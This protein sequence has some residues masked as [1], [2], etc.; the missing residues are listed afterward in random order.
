MGPTRLSNR[1]RSKFTPRLI[2]G[3]YTIIGLFWGLFSNVYLCKLGI[4]CALLDQVRLLVDWAFILV[5]AVLLYALIQGGVEALI[6]SEKALRASEEQF[7]QLAENV[8]E[9]FWMTDTKSDR[10]IYVSPVFEQ[11]WGRDCPEPNQQAGCWLD[12]VHPDERDR[13]KAAF[14]KRNEGNYNQEYR[15]LTPDGQIR[16]IRDQSFPIRNEAGEIYRICGIAHDITQRVQAQEVLERSVEER[17]KEIEQRRLVAEGLRGILAV[18]NSNQPLNI[19]LNYI[20]AQAARLLGA[21]AVSIYHL[22]DE[23]DV[24]TIQAAQGLDDDYI[25][26]VRVPVGRSITG[27]AVLKREPVSLPD[28]AHISLEDMPQDQDRQALSERLGTSYRALLAIPLGLGKDDIYGAITLYY[29][30]PRQFSAEDIDLAVAFSDQVALALANAQLRDHVERSAV[31]AERSRLARD[32]HDSVTQ[33]LFSASLTAEVLPLV[34]ERDQAEGEK[35]LTD[36]RQLTRGALAEMRTLLLELRPAV[37]MKVGLEEL[38]HQ[39]AEAISGRA[40]VPVDV[41]IID[42]CRLPSDVHVAFYR[43]A[44]EALNNVAKHADATQALVC[45]RCLDAPETEEDAVGAPDLARFT[46]AELRI[47]DNGHGFDLASTS[48]DNLGLSIMQE[49]VRAIG[50]TLTIESQPD[51][52]TQVTVIWRPPQRTDFDD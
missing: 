32:L 51:S 26:N 48:P 19:V 39:L 50:A 20:V 17:T 27:R 8:Q 10:L 38:L 46:A 28:I 44:Q 14:A 22:H 13:V 33:T 43:I 11:I 34:W 4:D 7:R 35:A 52:G 2:V 37:L 21:D 47:Q 15:I 36:L 42:K 24:L 18:L 12:H 9:I 23:D 29:Q 45:L 6:D 3:I 40:Q 25:A 31:A 30:K 1:H 5:T 41:G 16:W 49:R